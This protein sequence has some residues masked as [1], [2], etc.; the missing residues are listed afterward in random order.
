MINRL[1]LPAIAVTLSML[2]GC[3]SQNSHVLAGGSQVE[4]R[5]MQTRAFDTSNK[6]L[7][8][9][10]VI[11]TLQDLGFI[12]DKA[13]SDI[14]TVTA[15]KLSGYQIRMTVTVR[16]RGETQL[17]VRANAMYNLKAIED[18]QPYQDFFNSLSKAIFLTAHDVD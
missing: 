8:L 13:D 7:M 10:T 6:E 11:A 4:L 2:V 1:L 9:R 12:I 15:T 17:L 18:P 16:A 5:S 14:G 3:A